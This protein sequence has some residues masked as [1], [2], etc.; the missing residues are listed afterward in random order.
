MTPSRPNVLVLMADQM[1]AAV[2]RPG[3]PCLTPHLDRLAARG[4]RFDRAYT[5]SPTCSPARA[6]LMTGLLPH[7][8]GVLW[9]THN[10]DA[11]Q[12]C[13]RTDKPH[14]APRLAAAGYRTGYFGKWHVE[15]TDN[16]AHFG[17][18]VCGHHESAMFQ[19]RITA[20]RAAVGET[21]AYHLRRDHDQPP[22]YPTV[23]HYGV[24]DRPMAARSLGITADLAD[25]FLAESVTAARPWCCFVST[26]EPHDPFVAG[27]EAF[28]RYDVDALPADD[29]WHDP[30]V[31]R[32]GL[33][34]KQAKLW[35][36]LTD[37]QRRE[38][39]A[40]YYASI[41]EVDE[42]FGRLIGRIERAGQ[43]DHTLIILTSDHGELLG[44][45]GL[46]CK[47][48]SAFEQVYNIPL[49][50]AGPGVARGVVSGARVGLHDAAPTLLEMLGL[51]T[52]GSPDS[53][54]FASVLREPGQRDGEFT[55]GFAEYFGG[56][57]LLTQRVV[58][59]GAWKYVHNGFDADELYNLADD[60]REMTN[61]VERAEHRERLRRMTALMW[62]RVRE[63]GDCGLLRTEYPPLRMAAH[64]P[65][66]DLDTD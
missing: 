28:E 34:R 11:D 10:A 7:N 49:V 25:A 17:W 47:N 43:L 23:L 61:L 29:T 65:L 38:A 21:T 1:Q 64:G 40:C 22:D 52:I 14:W 39:A 48:V 53:R 19:Q 50:V 37:R 3:H 55:R 35:C 58:W 13:L 51:E 45:H 32:P 26:L 12:G 57:Y 30:L 6:S 18:Q 33:Y 42:Q 5:P 9:V 41:T 31:D 63:T 4:V 15:K 60:P 59:D 16:P 8:H 36:S 66:V 27:R 56:R 24:A 54:S 46:Y 20:A 62:R 2:L 44:A